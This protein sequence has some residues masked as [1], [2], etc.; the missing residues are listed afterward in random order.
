MRERGKGKHNLKAIRVRSGREAK[1]H[2]AAYTHRLYEL[3]LIK[4][5]II[6]SPVRGTL[7]QYT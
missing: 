7:I 4:S 5:F 2:R 3:F 6:L 1:V